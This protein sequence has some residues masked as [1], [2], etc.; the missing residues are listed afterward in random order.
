M[1]GSFSSTSFVCSPALRCSPRHF[2]KSQVPALLPRF[3]PNDWRGA[4][5]MLALVW[6]LSS[7][8]DNIAGRPHRRRD[9]APAFSR[10]GPH[11]L[12]SRNRRRG[13]RRRR[14]ERARRYHHHHDVDR[15]RFTHLGFRSD[16]RLR[17]CAPHFWPARGRSATQHSPIMPDTPGQVRV[18]WARVAIVALILLCAL[19]ANV[20]V[21]TKFPEAAAHFPFLG[22]T[23]WV[24]IL[25]SSALRRPDWEVLPETVRGSVFLLSLVL[26]A[27]LMPVEKLPAASWPTALGLGFLSAV[28]DNIP[29]TALALNQGGYDWG[30]LAYTVGFGGSMIWFGSSAGVA[31]CNLIP[32]RARSRSGCATAGSS[33][34]RTSSASSSCSPSGT[35]KPTRRIARGSRQP[36]PCPDRG[37]LLR[38]RCGGSSGRVSAGNSRRLAA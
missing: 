9:G 14:L 8:L 3:L 12:P 34:R 2:E 32:E 4:F 33:S 26:C 20:L 21:N 19:T 1:S 31:L 38:P 7:F 16:Y 36:L 15:R 11:R 17:R 30:F 18:D 27:S 29:L 28:F 25:L 37:S 6:I 10:Q 5:A 22:V 13:Q 23:V 35:G 24:V